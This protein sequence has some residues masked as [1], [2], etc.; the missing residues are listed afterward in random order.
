MCIKSGGKS[1]FI[2]R[3]ASLNDL[4]KWAIWWRSYAVQGSLIHRLKYSGY[5]VNVWSTGG[6]RQWHSPRGRCF[7]DPSKRTGICQ[8][9]KGYYIL[10]TK[11]IVRG[12]LM[13]S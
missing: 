2:L 10:A 4:V 7:A 13:E 8:P 6:S 9:N 11:Y 12:E 1:C 5:L 3:K